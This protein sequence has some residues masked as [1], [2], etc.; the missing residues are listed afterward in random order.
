MRHRCTK[1]RVEARFRSYFD[2]DGRPA[3][4]T[5]PNPRCGKSRRFPYPN[6]KK[7]AQLW[8]KFENIRD[9]LAASLPLCHTCGESH[10]PSGGRTPLRAGGPTGGNSSYGSR[11][12]LRPTG[13]VRKRI[14]LTL[15]VEGGGGFRRS[16]SAQTGRALGIP[17]PCR[18]R[19]GFFVAAPKP[20]GVGREDGT[21][22]TSE[23]RR[24]RCARKSSNP[25][26][27]P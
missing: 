17:I 3:P 27:F 24:R 8:R 21:R 11:P 26:S 2:H 4:C 13:Y 20:R 7:A 15:G 10:N 18:F 23:R 14:C 6:R 1:E 5:T 25:S 22:T 9:L 19:Q 12:G 16:L